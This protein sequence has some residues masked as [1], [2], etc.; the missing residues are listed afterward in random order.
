MSVFRLQ[1]NFIIFAKINTSLGCENNFNRVPYFIRIPGLDFV[2]V[3]SE[4][5]HVV[6]DCLVR[7]GVLKVHNPWCPRPNVG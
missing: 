3:F 7:V 6:S 2:I 5:K 4:S 1:V